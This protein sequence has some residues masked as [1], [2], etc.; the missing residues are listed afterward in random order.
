MLVGELNLNACDLQVQVELDDPS[1][2]AIVRDWTAASEFRP[3]DPAVKLLGRGLREIGI[4]QDGGLVRSIQLPADVSIDCLAPIATRPVPV[5]E[6]LDASNTAMQ[7]IRIDS[8]EAFAIQTVD[9][10][11]CEASRPL[12]AQQRITPADIRRLTPGSPPLAAVA[13]RARD[14]VTVI[15][16]RGSL[17]VTLSGAEA[18]QSGR[19]GDVIQVRNTASG[20]TIF[21]RIQSPGV[22]EAS[23]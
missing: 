12:R 5:G 3:L 14:N 21:A 11:E 15:A 17:Q 9:L 23:F 22:L 7:R 13:V 19:V 4:Y 8:E 20:K 2:Q 10:K 18:L 6:P 1:F 16:R